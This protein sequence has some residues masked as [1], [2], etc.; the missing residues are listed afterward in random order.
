MAIASEIAAVKAKVAEL[1]S[2]LPWRDSVLEQ[3]SY[4]EAVVYGAQS[5]ERLEQLTM[6]T[7]A[8][9]ELEGQAWAEALSLVQYRL[10]KSHL[11]Y[12]AQVRLG[13]HRRA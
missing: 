11:S 1:P 7:I 6:G 2:G 3:L 12:A 4:C 13:I 8:V 5:P 9:R 10:Q